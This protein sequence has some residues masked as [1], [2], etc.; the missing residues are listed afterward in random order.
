MAGLAIREKT[1]L[2]DAVNAYVV[3]CGGDPAKHV[4]GNTLRQLSVVS[5][6][7]AV[8]AIIRPYRAKQAAT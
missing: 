5:V 7:D 1:A 8:L 6:E 3:S 4:Y 2:W